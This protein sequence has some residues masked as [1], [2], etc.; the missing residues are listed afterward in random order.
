MSQTDYNMHK[1]GMGGSLGAL[2][3]LRQKCSVI[4]TEITLDFSLA[5]FL[6]QPRCETILIVTFRAVRLYLHWILAWYSQCIGTDVVFAEIG[7]T[8]SAGVSLQVIESGKITI[9]QECLGT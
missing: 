9:P 5:M 2:R 3:S 7:T 6:S 8:A 4:V 1:Y